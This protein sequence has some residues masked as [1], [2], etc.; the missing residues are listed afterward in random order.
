MYN[1]ATV[2]NNHQA[3]CKRVADACRVAGLTIDQPVEH[4]ASTRTAELYYAAGT[5]GIIVKAARS[6]DAGD[7]LEVYTAH[8]RWIK[9]LEDA[10]LPGQVAVVRPLAWIADPPAVCLEHAEGSQLDHLL[11]ARDRP[12]DRS[13]PL[14]QGVFKRL[15]AA[16]GAY[17]R[18]TAVGYGEAARAATT[19]VARKLRIPRRTTES[20]TNEVIAAVTAGDFGPHNVHVTDHGRVTILDIECTTMH[21]TVHRDVAWFLY[22]CRWCTRDLGSIEGKI[23]EQFLSGYADVGYELRG[24]RNRQ[25]IEMYF[26]LFHAQ[27]ALRR[28]RQGKWRE[29]FVFSVAA[30]LSWGRVLW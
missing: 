9:A 24:G 7:A 26:C 29:A 28:V 25:L 20:L 19:R 14:S 15:G 13:L 12:D 10:A 1:A 22:W 11:R 17:H 6:W 2:E 23:V 27:R 8:E 18:S 3:Q 5:S 21:V 30:S 4:V 16:L